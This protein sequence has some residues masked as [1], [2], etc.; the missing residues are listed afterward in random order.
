MPKMEFEAGQTPLQAEVKR[1]VPYDQKKFLKSRI[2]EKTVF[3]QH[4]LRNHHLIQ[5]QNIIQGHP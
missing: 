1:V 3:F 5:D 4:I 2:A